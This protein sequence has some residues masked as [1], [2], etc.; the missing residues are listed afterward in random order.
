MGRKGTRKWSDDA[1]WFIQAAYRYINLTGDIGFL[2]EEVI[3]A[4]NSPIL[5]RPVYETIKAIIRYSAEISVGKHKMPLLDSADWNDCLKLDSDYINGIEKE[6]RYKEQ[7]K[8]TGGKMGD[9]FES[10]YTESVMNAFLLKVA[11][12][13]MIELSEEK[14]D[15]KYNKN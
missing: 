1:L 14:G 3:V 10:N 7:L 13:E 12:D 9:P 8:R 6:K 15:L 4:G 5:T 11:I 2:D